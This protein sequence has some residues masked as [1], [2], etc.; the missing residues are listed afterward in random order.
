MKELFNNGWLFSKIHLESADQKI[1]NL[2]AER[3]GMLFSKG[4]ALGF[5][6][7]YFDAEHRGI[8]PS[9][10]MKQSTIN[11]IRNTYDNNAKTF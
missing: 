11:I 2:A 5:D 1:N 10:R 7:L 4:I 8:K 3:R 9:A 6:T